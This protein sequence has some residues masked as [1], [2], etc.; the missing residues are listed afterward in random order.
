MIP[1]MLS[2]MLVY[3]PSSYEENTRT[4]HQ[5][6][7]WPLRLV[8]V[9]GVMSSAVSMTAQRFINQITVIIYSV[10]ILPSVVQ[11]K[12]ILVLYSHP[13][14]QTKEAKCSWVGGSRIPL[15]SECSASY[16]VQSTQ[17]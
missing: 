17:C 9:A 3:M 6:K 11:M 2:H 14:Q 7:Q 15:E 12:G 13:H 4:V 10:L 16:G 5:E 8:A 1:Y